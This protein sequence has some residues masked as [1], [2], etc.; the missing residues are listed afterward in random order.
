M[1]EALTS[2]QLERDLNTEKKRSGDAEHSTRRVAEM[3]VVEKK[4]TTTLEKDTN[5]LKQQINELKQLNVCQINCV[6]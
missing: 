4:R 1:M 5:E 2:T 3:V 6:T